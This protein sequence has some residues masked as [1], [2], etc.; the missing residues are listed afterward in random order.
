MKVARLLVAP[1]VLF[2][3]LKNGRKAGVVIEGLP[4]D[5]ELHSTHLVVELD[6][7][8][9]TVKSDTFADVEEGKE[10]PILSPL[11]AKPR[12]LPPGHVRIEKDTES[13]S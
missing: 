12:E 6:C 11:T 10:I 3:L 9:F 2:D 5:A 8:S 1:T 13:K 4:D 7:I